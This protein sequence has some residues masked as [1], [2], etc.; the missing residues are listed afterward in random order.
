MD[1]HKTPKWLPF[2]SN[3]EV[4]NKYVHSLG[5]PENWNYYDIYGLDPDLLSMVPQPVGAV[6][7]LFPITE[8][9]EAFRKQEDASLKAIGQAVSDKVYFTNQTISNACA[10]VGMIHSIANLG[11]AM[12]LGKTVEGVKDSAMEQF[13]LATSTMDPI[14]RAHYLETNEAFT[15]AHENSAQEGQTEA[16]SLDDD[17]DQHYV[18]FTCVDGILYE[19]DGR[20][21][22]PISHG[23]SS[24]STILT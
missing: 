9:Y 5:V 7:L 11:D 2:E 1:Q 19:L 15:K 4:M 3:P 10:T 21:S 14:K 13:L 17:V 23:P 20:K 18:C 6:L 8:E 22:F 24:H 12:P 16:P